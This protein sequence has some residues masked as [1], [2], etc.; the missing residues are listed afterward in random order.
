M[1]TKLPRACPHGPW[2]SAIR[3]AASWCRSTWKSHH[4][5][6]GVL[7]A[8]FPPGG[9]AGMSLRR[10]KRHPWVSVRT[11]ITGKVLPGLNTP[12]LA[13]EAFFCA[14]TPEAEVV[15][16]AAQLQEESPTALL[17]TMLPNRLKPQR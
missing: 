13:R 5:P 4:A 3:W 6:A 17:E 16:C 2:L 12:K 9:S 11:I 7:V 10:W 15:R 1:S 8:S 14:H